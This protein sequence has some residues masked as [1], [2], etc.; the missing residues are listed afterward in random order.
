MFPNLSAE[1]ARYGI[2]NKDLA[3]VTGK[4]ERTITDKISGR[5]DFTWPE[6]VTIRDEL[7]PGISVEYLFSESAKSA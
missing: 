3:R 7:F 5:T 2:T 4:T 6:I 1:M